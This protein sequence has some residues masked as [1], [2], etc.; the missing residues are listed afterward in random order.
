MLTS[1]K[2]GQ[3]KICFLDGEHFRARPDKTLINRI[4]SNWFQC[5][6]QTSIGKDNE[7]RY[8]CIW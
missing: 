1:F 3:I 8:S 6:E 5:F 7:E 4:F 2:P